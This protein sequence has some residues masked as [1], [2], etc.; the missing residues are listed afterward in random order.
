[1]R[2]LI[3]LTRPDLVVGPHVPP[4]T[5]LVDEPDLAH[6][7]QH[8]VQ[9]EVALYPRLRERRPIEVVP[10]AGRRLEHEEVALRKLRHLPLHELHDRR[11]YLPR[12]YVPYVVLPRPRGEVEPD[13][14]VVQEVGA[15]EGGAPR[16][17]VHD[18]REGTAKARGEAERLG[19]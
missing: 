15:E 1:M 19:D 3:P 9:V 13:Q 16:L 6:H 17:R 4:R 2:A 10:Q 11:G 12:E 7:R 5:D 14:A 18:R 8:G